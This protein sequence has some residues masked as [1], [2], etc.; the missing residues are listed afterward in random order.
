M[1]AGLARYDEVLAGRIDHTICFTVRTTQKAYVWPARHH[2]FS[3]TSGY[4]KLQI[5][6]RL[7]PVFAAFRQHL[8]R[9]ADESR[10]CPVDRPA[11]IMRRIRATPDCRSPA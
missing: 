5:T 9:I 11:G 1:L 3:N 6:C 8:V 7:S 10:L 4:N 2:A